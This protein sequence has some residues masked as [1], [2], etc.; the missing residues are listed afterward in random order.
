MY[1]VIFAPLVFFFLKHVPILNP[2]YIINISEAF[3]FYMNLCARK[4]DVVSFPT[5]R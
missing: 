4:E 5:W 2:Q 1:T 3:I